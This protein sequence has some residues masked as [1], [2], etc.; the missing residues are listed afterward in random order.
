M[1][2]ISYNINASLKMRMPQEG[3]APQGGV[4]AACKVGL[5]PS[6]IEGLGELK[7]A[8]PL[9]SVTGKS[10]VRGRLKIIFLWRFKEFFKIAS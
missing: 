1:K 9:C 3:S 7:W 5:R 4:A 10:M 8:C 2:A 6:K